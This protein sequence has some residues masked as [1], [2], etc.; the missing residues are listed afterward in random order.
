M[1]T[2]AVILLLITMSW[3]PAGEIDEL[4]RSAVEKQKQRSMWFRLRNVMLTDIT[5]S[6]E[7]SV[8][9]VK[10]DGAGRVK[11]D[12]SWKQEMVII[13]GAPFITTLESASGLLAKIRTK[14][15]ADNAARFAKLQRRTE[16]EKRKVEEA[17]IRRLL[18]RREFWDEF[19][20]AFEFDLIERKDHNGRPTT[21]AAI[22]PDR[23]YR[24]RGIIDTK[25]FSK[26]EGLLW[27][28]ESDEE[29]ARLEIAFTD[30][31]GVGLGLGGKVY[32]GTRYSMELAKQLDNLWLPVQAETE[33]RQR[34]LL[35]KER[36][37][38]TV[39]FGNYKKF[40][41]NVKFQ[42]TDTK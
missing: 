39:K 42:V 26:L 5:F 9:K 15:E 41:T 16:V 21:I 33:L 25:Y 12:Q 18:E 35:F 22:R 4:V 10:F 23:A 40:E 17:R 8:R 24:P 7:F 19:L 30:D 31:V 32:K 11:D 13:D 27:I 3:Q 29:I 36:E 2:I 34:L 38:F 1:K 20:R 6:Y 37:T 28:D 14:E